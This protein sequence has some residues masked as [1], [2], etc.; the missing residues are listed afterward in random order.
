MIAVKDNHIRLKIGLT[1]KRETA[2]YE[3]KDTCNEILLK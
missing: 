3:F 1:I 2:K